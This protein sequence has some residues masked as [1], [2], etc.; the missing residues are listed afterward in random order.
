[1]QPRLKI[2]L[3]G[4]DGLVALSDWRVGLLE[5]IA[6]HGSL[7]AAARELGVPH[8]TAWQRLREMEERLG[9]RLVEASSGGAGGGES[10]L[11]P[12]AQDLMRRFEA[13]RAGL[14][15]QVVERFRVHFGD[16]AD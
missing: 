9:T 13:L 11:T 3:E 6:R 5:A 1:V 10:H 12:A 2:W 15:E 7:V 4:R 16:T 8:R 14:D